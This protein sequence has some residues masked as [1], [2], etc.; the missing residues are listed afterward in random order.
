MPLPFERERVWVVPSQV[1]SLDPVARERG[2]P[3]FQEGYC[4]QI[5]FLSHIILV[6]PP[7]PKERCD[8]NV[9]L[10]QLDQAPIT[11]PAGRLVALT[12]AT[13]V[14]DIEEAHHCLRSM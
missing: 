3:P 5:I 8:L 10:A 11:E 7:K 12:V 6:N 14:V 13:T 4:S 2:W 1:Q 9:L